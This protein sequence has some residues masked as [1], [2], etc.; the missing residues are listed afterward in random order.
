MPVAEDRD[1]SWPGLS[2][3]STPSSC[4]F[5]TQK[6]TYSQPLAVESN[7]LHRVDGREPGH[8]GGRLYR[9]LAGVLAEV[10]FQATMNSVFPEGKIAT[11]SNELAEPP[12]RTYVSDGRNPS[13]S[14]TLA[15]GSPM[16]ELGRWRED[17]SGRSKCRSGHSLL[18][19]VAAAFDPTRKLLVAERS[20]TL[21][22]N[23]LFQH[24]PTNGRVAPRA[25]TES[26]PSLV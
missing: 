21:D 19:S 15:G 10:Q 3:P 20:T 14:G 5:V 1:S 23:G 13:A 16:A 6:A 9:P 25:D 12:R 11:M 18:H 26:R 2:R 22:P 8:D 7:Q 17:G 24:G 4:R